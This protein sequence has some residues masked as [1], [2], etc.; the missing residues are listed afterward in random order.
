M[1]LPSSSCLC[2]SPEEGIHGRLVLGLL[3]GSESRPGEGI[4]GSFVSQKFLLLLR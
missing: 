4:Y 3:P 1:V 2:N